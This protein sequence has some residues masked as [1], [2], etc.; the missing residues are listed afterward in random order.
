MIPLLFPGILYPCIPLLLISSSHL[1]LEC[2]SF[3]ESCI[4][5]CRLFSGKLDNDYVFHVVLLCRMVLWCGCG[6]QTS[7]RGLVS[8]ELHPR[9][10]QRVPSRSQC[11]AAVSSS[12]GSRVEM[13]LK[14]SSRSSHT[15][16]C[17][18]QPVAPTVPL[19]LRPML[20]CAVPHC[21]QQEA[22]PVPR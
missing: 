9:P 16:R 5:C 10:S 21:D 14:Q 13:S 17:A 7:S 1:P 6:H 2:S 12:E 15:Q 4:Q 19:A 22:Y 18:M 20:R 8:G 3:L 11:Q